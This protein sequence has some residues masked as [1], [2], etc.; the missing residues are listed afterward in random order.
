MG[1][2][3][4][5]N[6]PGGNFVV[7]VG[8]PHALGDVPQPQ[9]GW[10]AEGATTTVTAALD[11]AATSPVTL[12]LTAAGT[13]GPDDYTLSATTITIRITTMLAAPKALELINHPSALL[14]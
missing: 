13:A 9:R 2:Y 7:G 1:E 11:A 10:P 4:L 12:G 6:L 8:E 5:R 14:R 3:R